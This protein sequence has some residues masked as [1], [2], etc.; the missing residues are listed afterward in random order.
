MQYDFWDYLAGW[1]ILG[2]WLIPLLLIVA[3]KIM[4][5]GIAVISAKRGY[6]VPEAGRDSVTIRLRPHDEDEDR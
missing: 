3:I 5:A 2:A 4:F 1:L 6:P